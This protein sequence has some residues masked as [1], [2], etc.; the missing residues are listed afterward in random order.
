MIGTNLKQ[1]DFPSRKEYLV[2]MAILY[3]R[4]H[5]GYYGINDDVFYDEA[6]CDGYALADDL[7]DEF[8]IDETI[9]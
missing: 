8:E 3:I 2:A 7:I 6:E 4:S 1:A 9:V 5:T